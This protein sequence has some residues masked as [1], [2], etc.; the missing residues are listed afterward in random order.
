MVS[1]CAPV[2]RTLYASRTTLYPY[3]R[4]AGG[5]ARRWLAGKWDISSAG[6]VV[7]AL[8]GLAT[9]GYRAQ[10]AE[11]FGVSPLAW[12]VALYV[13]VVRNSFAAG[14][15][16]E[17]SAWALLHKIV[18]PTASAYGSWKEYA[19]DYLLGR[20][21]WIG[22]LRG[23]PDEHFPAPQE[24]LDRHVRRLLDPDTGWSPWNMVTWNAI[25]E[26]D[27]PR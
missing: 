17:P 11:R 14:Y 7:Q 21:V 10:V 22:T 16:D 25:N 23:T 18:R 27:R 24:V 1:L 13:D 6:D 9:T 8:D 20:I 5:R 3:K 2:N 12:D 4:L 19:D 26:P 15:V